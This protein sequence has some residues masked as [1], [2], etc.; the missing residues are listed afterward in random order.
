M[1]H[2]AHSAPRAPALSLLL[3]PDAILHIST[4]A[5]LQS[6]HPFYPLETPLTVPRSTQVCRLYLPISTCEPAACST[7][8]PRIWR[9]P[10]LPS[11]PNF[12]PLSQAAQRGE[13]RGFNTRTAC[14]PPSYPLEQDQR[15]EA[16]SRGRPRSL[17]KQRL[18][19]GN[20]MVFVVGK[21]QTVRSAT[22]AWCQVTVRL[23]KQPQRL[24]LHPDQPR[25]IDNSGSENC[26]PISWPLTTIPASVQSDFYSHPRT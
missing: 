2:K 21:R 25:V 14:V 16:A 15:P 7:G 9:V 12:F 24:F 8:L 11:C 20:Q 1:V 22:P 18:A 6:R 19:W 23:N 4:L 3:P 17:P 13:E 5:A 26:L 10:A